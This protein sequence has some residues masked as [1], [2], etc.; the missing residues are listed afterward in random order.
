MTASILPFRNITPGAYRQRSRE[1]VDDLA[2]EVIDSVVVRGKVALF[3]HPDRTFV[4]SGGRGPLFDRLLERFPE[5]LVGVYQ[6]GVEITQVVEDIEA[7][8]QRVEEENEK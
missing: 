4:L 8:Q 5:S 6:T 3:I 1:D 2:R 7:R